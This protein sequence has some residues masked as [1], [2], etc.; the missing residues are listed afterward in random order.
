VITFLEIEHT[1]L[2]VRVCFSEAPESLRLLGKKDVFK[3]F[4]FTIEELDQILK[5]EKK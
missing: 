4:I 2:P 5:I 1:R 3:Y